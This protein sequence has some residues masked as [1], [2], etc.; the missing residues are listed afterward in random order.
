MLRLLHLVPCAL[1]ALAS[2]A[3]AAPR[4]RG[5]DF[6]ADDAALVFTV[7]IDGV[8]D[9]GRFDARLVD[10]RRV[11]EVRLGGVATAREWLETVDPLIERTLLHPSRG[12]RR[13]NLR[14]RFTQALPK[15]H[16]AAVEIMPRDGRVQVR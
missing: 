4:V 7:D 13:A 6:A 1:L 11:L 9:S 8:Y 15:G 2:I 10:R 3:G 12:A 14:I 16:A 5:V